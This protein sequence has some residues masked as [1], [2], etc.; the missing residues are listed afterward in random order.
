MTGLHPTVVGT[1]PVGS[2]PTDIALDN[3]S[4]VLYVS[5]ASGNI[6]EISSLN[7]SVIGTIPIGLN[8]HPTAMTYDWANRDVYV[9]EAGANLTAVISTSNNSIVASIPLRSQP[10][11]LG[12]DSANGD[13]YVAMYTLY[14]DSGQVSVIS[15]LTQRVVDNITKVNFP[16]AIACSPA[17]GYVFVANL[18]TNN[19]SVINGTTQT[20]FRS[21]AVGFAPTAL[22]WDNASLTAYTV[23]SSPYFGQSNNLAVIDAASLKTTGFLSWNTGPYAVVMDPSAGSVLVSNWF[24]STVAV[25]NETTN[26]MTSSISMPWYSLQGITV[27]PGGGRLYVMCESCDQVF[28]V[29]ETGGAPKAISVGRDPRGLAFDGLNGEVYVANFLSNNVSVIDSGSS[30]L[31][32][33]IPIPGP[34]LGGGGPGS[35]ACDPVTGDI[36]VGVHGNVNFSPGNVTIINGSTNRIVGAFYLW[37]GPGPSALS[38][39]AATNQVYVADDYLNVVWSFNLSTGNVVS[40]TP[41]GL[42]PEAMSYDPANGYLYVTNSGSSNVSVINTTTNRAV[43]SIA[44]GLAPMGIAFDAANGNLYVANEGSGTVSAISGA[45]N[46]PIA[47]LESGLPPGTEWWVNVT[48]RAPA[49]STGTSVELVLPPGTY[50]YHVGTVNRDFAANGSMLVVD[51]ATASALVTF[52]LLRFGV[53]FVETGLPLGTS[54]SVTVDGNATFSGSG[55]EIAFLEPNGTYSFRLGTSA[56]GYAS[57]PGEFTT[58]G[59]SVREVV[60]ARVPPGGG[61]P[62]WLWPAIGASVA[63]IAAAVLLAIRRRRHSAGK[64]TKSAGPAILPPPSRVHRGLS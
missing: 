9:A 45:F 53:T 42:S 63:I 32:Q 8:S 46:R 48:G 40:E 30:A 28:I 26:R 15:G 10:S 16:D 23:D 13:V 37:W 54:W 4:H 44:V 6:S 3:A 1:I 64:P 24:S 27:N 41:V 60:F 49:N 50:V 33:T 25:I 59:G 52:Q 19:V 36:Y 34:S 11:A 62:P 5:Q 20:V 61:N 21:V 22:A 29:N 55:M 7:D 14:N 47:F 12:F 38:V 35:V 39:D 18:G 43:G 2:G 58:L 51:F 56:H 17:E 31:I 57:P